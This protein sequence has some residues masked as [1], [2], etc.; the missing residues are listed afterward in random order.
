MSIETVLTE[1]RTLAAAGQLPAAV[2]ML[3][4]ALPRYP[5]HAGIALLFADLLQADGQLQA[6]VAAYSVA[7]RIGAESA[8]GWFGAGCAHL[9]LNASG[10]A[11]ACFGRAVALMPRSGPAHYNLG[12]SLFNLGRIESAVFSFARAEPLDSQVTDMA[13][14]SIACIIPGDPRADHLTVL[15][16]RRRWADNTALGLVPLNACPVPPTQRKLRVGY[17]SAFFGAA[18][19]MKPVFALINRHDRTIFEIYMLSDGEP[20]SAASGYRDHD[21]DYI[22]DLRGVTNER[23][24]GI[25]ADL[26]I[27]VLVDLNGYSFQQRLGLLMYRPAPH[28]V[29]WFNMFA[30]TGVAAVDWLV[31]D[32]HV[33]RRDEEPFYVERIHRLPGTY[34]AFEILYDVPDVAPPPCLAAGQITFGTLGSHYKL[35]DAV[36]SAWA[37]ILLAAPQTKLFIKNATLE[38]ESVRNDL[39]QRFHQLGVSERRMTLEGRSPHF[40]FLDAYRHIDIALDTFP[41]NGGTTTTEALWQ[42]VPVLT[43]DGDRWA[44]RTSA[45]L[46]LAAG[47][48]DWVLPD[49][50]GYV[51]RA[52]A[53]A[54]D[55]R[56]PA[57]L[58][59]LRNDMR[60]RLRSSAACD[61][62]DLCHAMEDFYRTI[63]RGSPKSHI[64]DGMAIE[65]GLDS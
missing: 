58:L 53:L 64:A 47:L 23:A 1:A 54:N 22:C 27:D 60:A 13:Q 51:D 37:R 6:A 46:L 62:D 32:G 9:A 36:V 56:T 11:A 18:N 42:G 34:L 2:A 4:T 12:K 25:I 52:I 59:T 55:V 3:Q 48:R 20:P 35:T 26:G 49:L 29:G 30:T 39:L 40:A 5:E 28:I 14:A 33:I 50:A 24:A 10:V 8:D 57:M 61:A 38:D 7:L 15:Q 63:A 16:A 19:W 45:S 43:F 65:S 31:G 41:Y 21:L 17:L 44:S